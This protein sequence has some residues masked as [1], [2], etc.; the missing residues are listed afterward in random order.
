VGTVQT[1]LSVLIQDGTLNPRGR[2]GTIVA[3]RNRPGENKSLARDYAGSIRTANADQLEVVSR[4]VTPLVKEASKSVIGLI[5]FHA[6][7][8]SQDPWRQNV[9][10]PI[11]RA[12]SSAGA[13]ALYV[14]QDSTDDLHPMI[15]ICNDLKSQGAS[16]FIFVTHGETDLLESILD[17]IRVNQ[18]PIVCI[19]I[20]SAPRPLMSVY[21]N[22]VD[23]GFRSADHLLACGGRSLLFYSPCEADWVSKR[24]AGAVE[25]F[26]LIR[27]SNCNFEQI[28]D[29]VSQEELGMENDPFRRFAAIR[30]RELFASGCR[31]DAIIAANDS[32]AAGLMDAASEYGLEPPRDFM[33][34]G[35]DD[36]PYARKMGLSTIRPPMEGIG[37]NAVKL[38]VNSWNG[39]KTGS[40]ICLNSDLIRR[41]ST[42]RVT[43]ELS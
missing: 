15:D 2:W 13:T 36:L 6:N 33:I 16:G 27:S 21:Y 4:P 3:H 28:I 7:Q 11:E 42:M 12:V 43:T 26:S 37:H 24:A 18:D 41:K 30:G 31:W 17:F 14:E 32:T 23:A 25:R 34:I 35:Y 8:G 19:G 29:P 1:A 38:I 20:S 9:L 39:D 22:N 10:S 40:H 5:N